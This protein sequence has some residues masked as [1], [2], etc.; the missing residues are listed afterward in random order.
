MVYTRRK[1]K[2]QKSHFL[3]LI[4][5]VLN[6]INYAAQ[7]PLK[8]HLTENSK[9]DPDSEWRVILKTESIIIVM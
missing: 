1:L 9:T 5:R 7:L 6:V 8:M 3:K 2:T 4:K